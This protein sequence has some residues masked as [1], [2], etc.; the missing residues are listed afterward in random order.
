MCPGRENRRYRGRRQKGQGQLRQ[1]WRRGR[2]RRAEGHGGDL[3]TH[4]IAIAP[5]FDEGEQVPLQCPNKPVVA[6]VLLSHKA[7][8]HKDKRRRA[9]PVITQSKRT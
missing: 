1:S 4:V 9:G 2:W 6:L 8:A 5:L 3:V 7:S